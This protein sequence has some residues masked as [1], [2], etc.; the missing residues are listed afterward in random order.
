MP[1]VEVKVFE[2][3][4]TPERSCCLVFGKLEDSTLRGN[5]KLGSPSPP[6]FQHTRCGQRRQ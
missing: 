5:L 1:L 4:L 6:A 3:E 2:D